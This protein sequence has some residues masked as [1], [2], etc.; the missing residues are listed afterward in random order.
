[1]SSAGL[2]FNW[3]CSVWFKKCVCKSMVLKC[4]WSSVVQ[5]GLKARVVKYGEV[6]CVVLILKERLG[7]PEVW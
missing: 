3:G 5:C 4:R 6:W 7:Q 2:T 1:M